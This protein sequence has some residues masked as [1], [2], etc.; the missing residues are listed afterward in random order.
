MQTSGIAI[1]SVIEFTACVQ[2]RENYFHT[3]HAQF[4]MDTN[5]NTAPIILYGNGIVAMQR[6]RNFACIPICRLVHSIINDFPKHMMQAARSRAADIH[7]W[8]HTDGF[9]AFHDFDIAY[10]VI[11]CHSFPPL[12]NQLL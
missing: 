11:F 12:P 2:L 4:F 10:A 6:N 1:G 8:P 3:T 7:T 9:K 5:R